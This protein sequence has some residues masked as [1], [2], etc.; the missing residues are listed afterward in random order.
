M[1]QNKVLLL[2]SFYY[3][4]RVNRPT[5]SWKLCAVDFANFRDFHETVE[6]TPQVKNFCKYVWLECT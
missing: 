5:G 1:N 6:L 3:I 2:Q 4:Q